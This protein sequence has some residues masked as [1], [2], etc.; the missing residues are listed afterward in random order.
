VLE[1]IVAAIPILL[2]LIKMIV[3]AIRETP[4]DKRIA[5]INEMSIAMKKVKDEKDPS[6]LAKF[7]SN[8]K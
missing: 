2:S 5:F 1:A 6:D 3:D 7:I 4:Q 8:L